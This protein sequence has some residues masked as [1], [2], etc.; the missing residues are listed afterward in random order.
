M[1]AN[2]PTEIIVK[3]CNLEGK[4]KWFR[5]L[6]KILSDIREQYF[7][8]FSIPI[9]IFSCR[10]NFT[11]GELFLK[12]WETTVLPDIRRK[13]IKKGKIQKSLFHIYLCSVSEVFSP[14]QY[15]IFFFRAI[16]S[17][18]SGEN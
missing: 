5:S 12:S 4:E 10:E 17:L 11:S 3:F 8:L 6:G 13:I 7:M 18:N 9:T 14:L 16:F 1:V 2:F 15:R